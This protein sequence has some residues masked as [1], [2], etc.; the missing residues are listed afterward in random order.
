MAFQ[1]IHEY[2]DLLERK[3]ELIRISGYVNPVLEIPEIVD[4]VSKSPEGGKALL[5]EN[6]G[7]D[8]PVLINAFGSN[9]RMALALGADNLNA[10]GDEIESLFKKLV[11]PKAGLMEKLRM[12]PM[13]G[14]ISSWM[15]KSV[16]GKGKCQEVVM[17]EP[18]MGKLPVLTCWPAD[19][20]PFVT[21][22][23]CV[24]TRDPETGVRNVGMYRMQVFGP[25]LT[26]M[27]WHKH[28]T[29]ARH[30]NEYKKRGERMPISV[31]LGG[32]PAYTYAATAPLPDNIDEYLLAGFLRKKRVELV[33]CITNDLEIPSNADFVIE[34][35][36]DPEE[37][38]IWEGP[39]G[40]HTGFY[41]LADWYPK[42]HVTCITTGR[43]P[44]IRLP[45]LVSLRRKMRTS[46]ALRS[47]FSLAR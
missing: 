43:M 34:G 10:I 36:V 9:N 40:D 21:L 20:G 13:L 19:G 27:H 44:F 15:P 24:V 6:T 37:D 12:L 30:F 22:P 16:S 14:Q 45:L 32:D 17:K 2:I 4:R 28:K 46:V 7:T 38:F 33:K 39:F 8:F 11:S 18:D 29:G 26:G 25:N 5:F 47:A 31:V 1:G 41:S 23:C 3:G 35:Y 42:F